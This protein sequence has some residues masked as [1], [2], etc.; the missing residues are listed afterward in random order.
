MTSQPKN[1]EDGRKAHSCRQM[2]AWLSGELKYLA[3]F[4]EIT[5]LSLKSSHNAV[6]IAASPRVLLQRMKARGNWVVMEHV[7]G[8]SVGRCADVSLI[9]QRITAQRATLET[10]YSYCCLLLDQ[11]FV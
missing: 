1:T 6:Q 11:R 2:L 3:K 5:S 9:I 7:G 4:L 10:L 8:E